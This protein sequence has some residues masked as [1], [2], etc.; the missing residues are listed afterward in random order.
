MA[1]NS[2]NGKSPKAPK[3]EPVLAGDVAFFSQYLS[4]WQVASMGP[5]P[6]REQ[7]AAA[8]ALGK[9]GKPK[10]PGVEALHIAMCLRPGGCTVR[11]FQIAGSCGPANN[12]RRALRRDY[13]LVTETK[14]GNPYAFTLKLTP[15][16]QAQLKAFGVAVGSFTVDKSGKAQTVITAPKPAAPKGPVH[17]TSKAKMPKGAPRATASAKRPATAT[18][19]SEAPRAAE[20]APAPRMVMTEAGPKPL[21]PASQAD[22]K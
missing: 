13:G 2:N 14:S 4:T 5:K 15:K 20:Q 21:V 1:T 7:F 11:Q 19:A 17:L 8:L 22:G 18:P 10:R 6:T 3:A 9:A 12:H 16:G